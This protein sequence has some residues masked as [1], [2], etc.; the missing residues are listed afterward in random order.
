MHTCYYNTLVG[1]SLAPACSSSFTTLDWPKHAA[2]SR[3]GQPFCGRRNMKYMHATY[4]VW[5]SYNILGETC[6]A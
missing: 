1:M 4:Y 3:G 2:H 6:C 5:Y